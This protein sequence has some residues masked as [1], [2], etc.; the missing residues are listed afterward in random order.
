MFVFCCC[1]FFLFENSPPPPPT[2]SAVSAEELASENKRWRSR[3]LSLQNLVTSVRSGLASSEDRRRSE[4][5]RASEERA[6]LEEVVRRLEGEVERIGGESEIRRGVIEKGEAERRAKDEELKEV[7]GGGETIY[8]CE[9]KKT[10][11]PPPP[12]PP[13]IPHHPLAA[14]VGLQTTAQSQ[15]APHTPH[16]PPPPRY[17]AHSFRKVDW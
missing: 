7:R 13:H 10:L 2:P 14:Q 4:G 6:R 12:P 15:P 16:P 3:V 11:Q 9:N 8:I 1:F 17:I 5:I